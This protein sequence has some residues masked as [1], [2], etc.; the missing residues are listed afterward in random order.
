MGAIG[1]VAVT[2]SVALSY[3]SILGAR[4]VEVE[5]EDR[6][7]PRRVMRLAQIEL[8]TNVLH[9]DT[10]AA[11]G[12]LE[13]DRW[14]LD[15][16]VATRLPGTITITI[17][18]RSPVLVMSTSDERRL[19]AA[20]GT[21]LGPAPRSVALPQV[22][23]ASGDA[24]ERKEVAIAGEVVQ[25]MAPALRARVRTVTVAAGDVTLVVDGGVQVRYGAGDETAAK[26]Q[27]LRAIL[28]H[29]DEV[30]G[31]LLS[32]D[33]SSPSAPTAR[34]AGSQP[35]ST[36]PDPSAD[37]EVVSNGERRDGG[38]GRTEE[39]QEEIPEEGDRAGG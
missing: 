12:R 16:T 39:T 24:M 3:T 21:V 28:D 38:E 26:A 22:V 31:V 8:G 1:I 34:F 32:V 37:A 5:G 13:A 10:A 9:L 30:Q 15:A 6:L 25:A 33:L 17:R 11:E 4:M 2:G 20:D 29:A 14:I 36:G 27:A 18:E 19:V 35:P 7:P 23:T